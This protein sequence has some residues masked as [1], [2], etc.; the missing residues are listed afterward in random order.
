M[1]ST[2][3]HVTPEPFVTASEE[4]QA[5]WSAGALVVV[6]ADSAATGGVSAL[7]EHIA[8][9]GFETPYHV[10]H[11]EDEFFYVVDG[12][13]EC[14]HGDTGEE[15]VR[16]GPNDTVFLPRDIPHGFH[17]VSA[18]DC[19]MV[20]GLTPG[21]FEAFFVEAGEPAG[22][23]ETPPPGEIDGEALATLG[24][25]YRLDILGPIPR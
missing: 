20:I 7:V 18:H 15:V 10:H 22:A 21:G 2:T 8:A 23:M 11:A 12:E 19:R 25:K 5:L 1:A 17:V 9:P 4:G 16:A 3:D 24:S 6:K 13:I 14:Y